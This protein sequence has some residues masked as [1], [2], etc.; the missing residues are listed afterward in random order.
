MKSTV[1][2]QV[3]ENIADLRQWRCRLRYK[4]NFDRQPIVGFV[5]TMGALHQ[6]HMS[7]VQKALQEC[8][9]VVVSIFV[10]PIQFVKGEDFDKYPRPFEKDLELCVRAGVHAVFH[11][12]CEQ[13]Y[14]NGQASLTRVVPPGELT[15]H[16]CGAF[17]PGHFEGVATVVAKL[18]GQVEPNYAYFGEK[19]Y[20]QLVVVR[21]M[22]ADLDLPVAVVA[23]PTVRESDGLAMSSRNVYLNS[24]ERAVAPVLHQTLLTVSKNATSKALT[25]QEALADGRR[26][27]EQVPGL[28]LQYLEACD[29]ITLEP[30][31]ECKHPMVV[32][33][34]AKLGDVRLID[35]IIVPKI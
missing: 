5:P 12:T 3:F 28:T 31:A 34:A 19:D 4:D 7:L 22:V 16:L 13:M 25:L 6:G 18:F 35:N 30:V 8:S 20:Q 23:S 26:K 2:T 24:G 9:H 32:L 10:N 11:P 27:L 17:R 14:P 29:A 33:V 15:G 21:R 1:E